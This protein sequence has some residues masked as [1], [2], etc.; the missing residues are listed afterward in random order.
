M[1]QEWLSVVGLSL[2][3]IGFLLIAFEWHHMFIRD[4]Y[5]RQK[6]FERDHAKW[7]AEMDG[8]EFDDDDNLE[9]THWQEFQRLLQ[10]DTTYRRWLFFTGIALIITGFLLQVLGNWPV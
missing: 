2:D 9:Y 6:R 8:D 1:S 7:R 10:K 3:I 5:M 4:V